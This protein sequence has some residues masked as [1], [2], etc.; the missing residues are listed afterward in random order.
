MPRKQ[1]LGQGARR[2]WNVAQWQS[3]YPACTG[4]WFPTQN[5]TR[6]HHGGHLNRKV[7]GPEAATSCV[8]VLSE[9]DKGYDRV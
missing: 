4:T 2:D 6:T 5:R 3:T 7:L 9:E 1:N 8:L